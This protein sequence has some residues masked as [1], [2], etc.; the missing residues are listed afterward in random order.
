MSNKLEATV[1][2]ASLLEKLWD[3][4]RQGDRL[5]DVY[6]PNIYEYVYGPRRDLT[7]RDMQQKLGPLIARTNDRLKRK[8]KAYQIIPGKTKQ[9]Y[10][11]KFTR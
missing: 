10:C 11:I 5:R 4:K 2:Q 7:V 8:G 1:L 9:T 3:S 6:I